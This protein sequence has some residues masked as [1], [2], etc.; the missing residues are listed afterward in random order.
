MTAV[1]DPDWLRTCFAG[2]LALF[3]LTFGCGL[4]GCYFFWTAGLANAVGATI[5]AVITGA[6][7][8]V[9]GVMSVFLLLKAF[10]A[11]GNCVM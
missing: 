2:T 3:G 7:G 6:F 1:I 9:L 11:L 5:P 4:I 10:R 8:F